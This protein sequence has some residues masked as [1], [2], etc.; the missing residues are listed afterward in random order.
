MHPRDSVFTATVPI[1]TIMLS[2]Q[3]NCSLLIKSL[4]IDLPTFIVHP[5]NRLCYWKHN[6]NHDNLFLNIIKILTF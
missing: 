5:I 2:S 1:K 6:L 4:L 3:D